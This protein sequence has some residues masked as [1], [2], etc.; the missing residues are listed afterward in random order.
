M[1]DVEEWLLDGR[2]PRYVQL[3]TAAAP[4]GEAT[5]SY[6]RSLGARAAHRLGVEQVF[7]DVR[8]SDDANNPELIDLIKGAGAIYF[9]G[10][11]PTY[12]AKTLAG[13]ALLSAIRKEWLGVPAWPAAAQVPWQSGAMCPTCATRNRVE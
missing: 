12:L 8:S 1:H 4:E 10:G 3:A 6:W 11:N 5:T 13:T 2:P 9:S 7:V